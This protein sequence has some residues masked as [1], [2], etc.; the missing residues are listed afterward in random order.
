MYRVG[1]LTFPALSAVEGKWGTACDGSAC[2]KTDIQQT[3]LEN[4]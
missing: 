2:D 3:V 1:L 4:E